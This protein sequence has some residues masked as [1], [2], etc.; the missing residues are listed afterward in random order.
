[1]SGDSLVLAAALG[2]QRL[3]AAPDVKRHALAAPP[4]HQIGDV[5][6]RDARGFGDLDLRESGRLKVRDD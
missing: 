3:E 6:L 2:V 5:R 4:V 1:M